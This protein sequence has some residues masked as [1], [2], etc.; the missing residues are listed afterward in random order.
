MGRQEEVGRS[1]RC[2][3]ERNVYARRQVR[4][5]RA[6]ARRARTT[7]PKDRQDCSHSD[8]AHRRRR[9]QRADALHEQ[10]RARRVLSLGTPFRAR[11]PRRRRRA[12]RRLQGAR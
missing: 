11:L 8:T 3:L 5:V 6:D 12:D 10:R 7:R 4:T 9:V 1:L 2:P